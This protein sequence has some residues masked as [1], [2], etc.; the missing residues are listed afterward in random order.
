MTLTKFNVTTMNKFG[1]PAQPNVQANV[2]VSRRA[3]NCL[4]EPMSDDSVF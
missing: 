2:G 4:N 3:S 1:T